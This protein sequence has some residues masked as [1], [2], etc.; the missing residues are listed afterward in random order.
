MTWSNS[1]ANSEKPNMDV[2]CWQSRRRGSRPETCRC[3]IG[4]ASDALVS[5][6]QHPWIWADQV[7]PRDLHYEYENYDSDDDPVC[8]AAAAAVRSPVFKTTVNLSLAI[9]KAL[10]R[11]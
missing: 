7:A 1:D 8:I 9:R 3:G 2:I 4:T 10:R 11:Y 5:K 6:W